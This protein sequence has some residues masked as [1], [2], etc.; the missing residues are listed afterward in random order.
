MNYLISFV[1]QGTREVQNL[2][3][4]HQ[5]KGSDKKGVYAVTLY[6]W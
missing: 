3:K 5:N 2:R 4:K 1:P 6:C